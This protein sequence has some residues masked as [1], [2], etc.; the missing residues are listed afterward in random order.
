[1]A[2]RVA[3]V[4]GVVA[5]GIDL[6]VELLVGLYKGF[7]VLGCVAEVDVVVG[8]AVHEQ[9]APCQTGC[10][11]EGR[12]G[13]VARAVLLR[14]LHEALGIDA[15]V[16]SPVGGRR[17]GDAGTEGDGSLAQGHQRHVAAVAPAPDGDSAAI[18]VRL[19]RQ[20]AGCLS[21]VASLQLTDMLV[22]AFLEVGAASA[23]AASIDTDADDALLRQQTLPRHAGIEA[24]APFVLDLLRA[25]T[26]V[27]VH[28]DGVA[29]PACRRGDGLH[30]PTVQL[31]AVG[32]GECEE[33]ACGHALGAEG[34]GYLAI[35][36]KRGKRLP[37]HGLEGDDGCLGERRCG[38][39]EVL[40]VR[41]KRGAVGA[42]FGG[43]GGHLAFLVGPIDRAA[44]GRRAVAL[45]EDITRLFVVAVEGGD[46]IAAAREGALKRAAKVVEVEVVVAG[47]L[48][49]QHKARG[50]EVDVLVGRLGKPRVALL[51]Q[52]EAAYGAAGV[53]H[54]E[55]HAVLVAVKGDDGQLVLVA[56]G[57][58]LLREADAGD[59]AVGIQRDVQLARDAG[60][61]VER[62]DG[63][64]A[65]LHPRNRIFIGIGAGVEGIL[66]AGGIGALVEGDGKLGHVALDA[67]H[68]SQHAAVGAE[69]V[70]PRLAE[71]LLI[72]P[73]GMAV[74]DLA[75]HAVLRHLHLGVVEHQLDEE[76]V[77]L[78]HEGNHLAVGRERGHLLRS[79]LRKGRHPS[80]RHVVDEVLRRERAAVD[81]LRL[82]LD[83][84]A[85]LGRAEDVAV[86]TLKGAPA[87]IR[88]TEKGVHHLARLERIAQDGIGLG[89]RLCIV[90]TVGKRGDATQRT[91]AVR[92]VHQ[93]VDGDVFCRCGHA[94]E[95][96]HEKKS[97][98]H[99]CLYSFSMFSPPDRQLT[100]YQAC[101][102]TEKSWIP[103]SIF[104][105]IALHLQ[106]KTSANEKT[107]LSR[108]WRNP[109]LSTPHL[110]SLGCRTMDGARHPR[111]R[112][113]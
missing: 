20:P 25:G 77:V 68:I 66:L 81:A 92:T 29:L 72:H 47:A 80:V 27:L 99:I 49:L 48:A 107:H 22:G 74:D 94:D 56:I 2:P 78:A 36:D 83:E 33:L 62:V 90:L 69:V 16:E 15:V 84:D 112:P 110:P 52:G 11:Q 58:G 45:V 65:V 106:K 5:V 97:L 50:E 55:V 23:R 59:V 60:L 44:Q 101:E 71:L 30:H 89:V 111:R 34:S 6:H 102:V 42:G 98:F 54:V 82:R 96:Q 95:C 40:Q 46:L 12:R 4:D 3:A 93:V 37:A 113:G 61:D 14:R 63:D 88:R 91:G 73:V 7:A 76:E 109:N 67:L 8:H 13:I 26:A 104:A 64:G 79:A 105:K 51:T 70:V 85:V 17:D 28:D 43:E 86:E 31:D 53:G 75:P 103:L 100:I 18:D 19:L 108:L 87:A 9:Q 57:I 41:R 38:V 10:A 39:D 21:L 1:M 32:G 24:R 35:I